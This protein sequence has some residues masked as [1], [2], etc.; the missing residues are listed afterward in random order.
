MKDRFDSLEA[1]NSALK[2]ENEEL[3]QRIIALTNHLF[4]PVTP[5]NA[6][7]LPATTISPSARSKTNAPPNVQQQNVI[8]LNSQVTPLTPPKRFVAVQ[9]SFIL[10]KPQQ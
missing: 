2:K 3:K 5:L 10:P 4:A 8:I 1:E 7:I 9:P 6:V